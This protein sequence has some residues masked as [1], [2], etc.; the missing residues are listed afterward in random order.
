MLNLKT[1]MDNYL[2]G[3]DGF[4]IVLEGNI[5]EDFRREDGGAALIGTIG[6]QNIHVDIV[7]YDEDM[8]HEQMNQLMNHRIRVTI[9]VID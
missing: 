3:D 9:E 8:M 6:D 5:M 2:K 7:S 4:Q 1:E